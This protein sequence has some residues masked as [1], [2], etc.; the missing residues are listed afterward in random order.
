MCRRDMNRLRLSECSKIYSFIDLAS[1]KTSSA[2]TVSR[3]FALSFDSL[4]YNLIKS[5]EKTA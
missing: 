2:I 1:A 3:V 5:L 4:L